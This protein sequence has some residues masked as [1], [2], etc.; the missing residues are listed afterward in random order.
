[1]IFFDNIVRLC[2]I[3]KI[4]L[5]MNEKIAMGVS[6]NY[7]NIQ[8]SVVTLAIPPTSFRENTMIPM[9]R[10]ES[11]QAEKKRL[12]KG[13]NEVIVDVTNLKCSSP[14]FITILSRRFNS[15]CHKQH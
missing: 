13:R 10:I 4:F 8:L 12:V 7:E 15:P 6:K 11:R 1:M 14:I 3:D 9:E 5:G 2:T